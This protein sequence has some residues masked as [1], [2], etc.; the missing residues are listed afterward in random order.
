MRTPAV[1]VE[2]SDEGWRGLYTSG[3]LLYLGRLRLLRERGAVS[4]PIFHSTGS[5]PEMSYTWASSV[6]TFARRWKEKERWQS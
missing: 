6:E 3:R 1:Q 2:V 5:R 4:I